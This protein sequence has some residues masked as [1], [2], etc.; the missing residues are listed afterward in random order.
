MAEED[1]QEGIELA[2]RRASGGP[3][4]PPTTSVPAEPRGQ[5]ARRY[6]HRTWLYAW[7]SISIVVFVL[8][9]I[10][11]AQNTRSVRVGW[12]FGHSRVSL[13]L[14]IVFS[15]VLGWILG[16]ATSAI[17]RRRTRRVSTP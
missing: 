17:F 10:L 16:I 2:D 9:V 11:I 12:V 5:R 15:V 6:A 1:G 8:I 7:A 3:S 14:L 13:V 4:V